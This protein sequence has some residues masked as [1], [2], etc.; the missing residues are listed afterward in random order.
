V[1]TS[2]A[3]PVGAEGAVTLTGARGPGD[4]RERLS[5]HVGE[6]YH[7]QVSPGFKTSARLETTLSVQSPLPHTTLYSKLQEGVF[8]SLGTQQ[9]HSI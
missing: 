5:S 6:N 2:H 4:M 1:T 8:L 7:H 9:D 3:S